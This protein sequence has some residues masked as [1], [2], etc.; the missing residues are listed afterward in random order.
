MLTHLADPLSAVLFGALMISGRAPLAGGQSCPRVSH[1]WSEPRIASVSRQAM[2][3]PR[4]RLAC[5]WPR[6][7]PAGSAR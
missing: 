3:L 7:C 5:Y 1:R 4:F 2:R 6:F